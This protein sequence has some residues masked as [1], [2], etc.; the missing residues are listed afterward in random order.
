MFLCFVLFFWGGGCPAFT[1]GF[2][3]VH[4]ICFSPCLLSDTEVLVEDN[5][6]SVPGEGQRADTPGDSKTDAGCAHSSDEDEEEEAHKQEQ[7]DAEA[8]DGDGAV[9]DCS[10]SRPL[11][12]D[13]EDEEEQGAPST[14]HS[15]PSA[16]AHN[17]SE[18]AKGS[19]VTADVFSKAPFP[20]LQEDTYDVFANAPFPRA[21]PAA[22]QQPDVFSQAPFAKKKEAAHPPAAEA[23]A[24][25]HERGV[26]GQVTPQPFRPQALAKYSRHFEGPVPSPPAPTHRAADPFVSAPFH[27][28]APQEKR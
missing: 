24:V 12:L 26:L 11:L 10:G 27:F 4:P 22:P 18:P 14:P 20:V 19:E 5:D 15:S 8:T 7:Q 2:R 23:H 13:S 21:P 3:F 25:P 28:K 17:H 16:F 1:C 6:C 9:L